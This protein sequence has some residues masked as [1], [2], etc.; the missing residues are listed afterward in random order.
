MKK[1][2][3][4]FIALFSVLLI[5]SL[6]SCNQEQVNE[7]PEETDY[8]INVTEDAGTETT[9]EDDTKQIVLDKDKMKRICNM[10]TLKCKMHLSVD[11]TKS[12]TSLLIFKSEYTFI[13]EYDAYYE[14][15]VDIGEVSVDTENRSVT[16]EISKPKLITC[17]II[18]ESVSKYN[19]I[20]FDKNSILQDNVK[21]SID[22]STAKKG[23]AIKHLNDLINEKKPNFDMAEDNARKLITNYISVISDGKYQVNFKTIN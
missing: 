5:T 11:G 18:E 23:E 4:I 22:E 2:V 9:E 10:S 8:V 15:G 21:L 1:A 6:S 12:K 16:E 7:S 17:D 19:I 13:T 20:V 14:I 3:T